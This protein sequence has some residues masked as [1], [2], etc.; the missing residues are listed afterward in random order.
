[1][2]AT[3][4]EVIDALL[5]N[6][7]F[8]ESDSLAKART[9]ATAA[10]RWLILSP[11]SQSDQGSSMSMGLAQ[12]ENLLGRARAYISQSEATTAAASSVRFLSAAEGFRR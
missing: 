10:T 6:A 2:A 11:A 8:E 12:I 1:M 5:D 3:I 9:F 4:D 7:D